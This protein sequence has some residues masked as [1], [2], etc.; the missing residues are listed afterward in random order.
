MHLLSGVSRKQ[1]RGRG[2]GSLIRHEDICGQERRE[3]G[4]SEGWQ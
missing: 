1:D 4:G 2:A 3:L